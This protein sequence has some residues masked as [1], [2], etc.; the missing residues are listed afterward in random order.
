[1]V[2]DGKKIAKE[3]TEEIISKI[4]IDNL[5]PTMVV[6][7]CDPNFETRKYLFLKQS[8]AEA[9]GISLEAVILSSESTTETIIE[10]IKEQSVKV[11][12]IIVQLPLPAHIDTGVVLA[13]IP[14]EL[15]VDAF[16]YDGSDLQVL[17]PVVGAIDEISTRH[18]VQW[19]GK[20]VVIFGQGRLVGA[21][22][23]TY[24]HTKGARVTILTEKST[25]IIS[26]V[27][28][29]DIIIL[30]V[31]K[32]NLLTSDMIKS[33]VIVFDAGASEDGGLLVGDASPQVADKASLFTPVPGGIGPITIAILFRNLVKLILHPTN[34]RP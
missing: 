3:I 26:V 11:G 21:P 34:D 27:E 17:P 14:T 28:N 7:A 30:G 25:D 15:D 29:A 2:I 19:A 18:E 9:L 4:K 20:K 13:S 33:G 12:G 32:P 8:K 10:I 6:I 5:T 16:G 31:G 1:M 24:A 23:T 22:A